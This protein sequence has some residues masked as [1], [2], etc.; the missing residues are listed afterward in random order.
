MNDLR[1]GFK[2]RHRKLLYE[3]IDMVPPPNQKGLPEE[4]SGRAD[5]RDSSNGR[6]P[7]GCSRT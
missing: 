5:Q 7:I 2:E 6:A 3:A 1:V 4:G